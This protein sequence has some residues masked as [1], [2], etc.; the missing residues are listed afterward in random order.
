MGAVTLPEKVRKLLLIFFVSILR[1]TILFL[2]IVIPGM[3]LAADN[4][5]PRVINAMMSRS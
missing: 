3:S 1:D 2:G 5:L 4:R